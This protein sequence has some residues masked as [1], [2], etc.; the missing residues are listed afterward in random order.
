MAI[1]T[2]P[3][4]GV[5]KPS[6]ADIA[7]WLYQIWTYLQANPIA[8]EEELTRIIEQT[9]PDAVAAYLEEH[10]IDVDY[11]VD[12][13]NGRTGNVVV[14]YAELVE[15]LTVP[16]Y[17][18]ANDEVGQN[19]LVA[20]YAE[21]CRFAVVDDTN[22][23]VLLNNNGTITMLP[24]GGGGSSGGGDGIQSINGTIY[25]D[26]NGNAVVTG[27][28]IPMTSSDSTTVKAAIDAK[29]ALSAVIN[30]IYPVG[31]IYIST[32]NTSP[33]TL[34]PG[35]TWTAIQ[36]RFLLA[37]G[38]TYSGGDTGGE[39]THTLTVNEMPSHT[40]GLVTAESSGSYNTGATL[41]DTAMIPAFSGQGT[42]NRGFNTS[43]ST[44]INAKLQTTGSGTA[45]NNMP[46]YLAVFMWERTA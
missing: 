32:V 23:F 41:P 14:E 42:G 26:A 10:P 2:P 38:S 29:P 11:P 19:D 35:T 34:F 8:N 31:A 4:N 12:S 15:G 24:I 21:G 40:H 17:R 20:A 39:A 33:A 16:V 43:G 13:V 27:G 7:S 3:I 5:F 18:A 28:N 46:P 6:S 44:S 45:H 37:A 22:T 1:F 30:T 36:D 25:P 9:L